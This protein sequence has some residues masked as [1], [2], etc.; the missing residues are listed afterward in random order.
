[1]RAAACG[2]VALPSPSAVAAESASDYEAV[3]AAHSPFQGMQSM[4]VGSGGGRQSAAH[5]KAAATAI[6]GSIH[7]DEAAAVAALMSAASG[8]VEKDEAA[9]ASQLG[10]RDCHS[11]SA[12]YIVLR[13]L[14]FPET[15]CCSQLTWSSV[16]DVCKSTLLN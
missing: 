9:S 4:E 1:M 6:S 12:L 2:A 15:S 7:E 16:M 11:R 10:M 13:R 3:S 5:P 14:H 8:D